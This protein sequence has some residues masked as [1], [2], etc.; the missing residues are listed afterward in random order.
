MGVIR[1]GLLAP[2]HWIGRIQLQADAEV[3]PLGMSS[4]LEQVV[5]RC[6]EIRISISRDLN[7]DCAGHQRADAM[8][9]VCAIGPTS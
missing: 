5:E 6:H 2:A 8:R 9:K 7:E 1:E 4:L 3:Q